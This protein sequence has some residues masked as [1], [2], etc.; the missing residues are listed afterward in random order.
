MSVEVRWCVVEAFRYE[1]DDKYKHA[2][3]IKVWEV[4]RS[5][6]Q[7]RG[8]IVIDYKVLARCIS[9]EEPG[10]DLDYLKALIKW[11]YLSSDQVPACLYDQVFPPEKRQQD[12]RKLF[13][14]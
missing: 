5:S 13:P 9:K 8:D 1:F 7:S 6:L 11:Q 14:V 4:V 12:W 10:D 3:H 2:L